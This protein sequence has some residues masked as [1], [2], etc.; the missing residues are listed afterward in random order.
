MKFQIDPEAFVAI[1]TGAGQAFS[2]GADLKALDT[3]GPEE[4]FDSDFVYSGKG[5]LGFTRITD[6]MKPVT[7]AIHGYC[8]AGGMEMVAWCDIRLSS[9]QAT[10]RLLE[11]RW[12]VPLVDGGTL[13]HV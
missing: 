3:L 2:T 4:T 7:M 12:N 11:R 9:D 5:Y 10:F 6:L 8:F 1:L 13:H